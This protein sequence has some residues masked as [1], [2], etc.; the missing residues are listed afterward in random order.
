MLTRKSEE[1]PRSKNP[2]YKDLRRSCISVH[3]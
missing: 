1:T 3:G 2:K